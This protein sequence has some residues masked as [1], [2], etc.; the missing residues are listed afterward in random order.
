MGRTIEFSFVFVANNVKK[1]ITVEYSLTRKM[2]R[3]LEDILNCEDVKMMALETSSSLNID[4]IEIFVDGNKINVSDYDNS[5]EEIGI[6][7]GT[8][9][10]VNEKKRGDSGIFSKNI[11]QGKIYVMNAS[12]ETWTCKLFPDTSRCKNIPEQS[13]NVTGPR[14]NAGKLGELNAGTFKRSKGNTDLELSPL[15]Q[16]KVIASK[17]ISPHMSCEVLYQNWFPGRDPLPVKVLFHNEKGELNEDIPVGNKTAIVI[18]KNGVTELAKMKRKTWKFW[19]KSPTWK[20][21]IPQKSL[22]YD[23]HKDLNGE[24]CTVCYQK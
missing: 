16:G 14:A 15:N 22:T 6:Q 9:I 1:D 12:D 23:P 20:P 4:N 17:K 13:L 2:N 5:L 19:K 3:V 7:E 10:E 8:I 18:K 11:K 24:T 21:K